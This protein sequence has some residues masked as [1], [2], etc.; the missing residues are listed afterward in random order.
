MHTVINKIYKHVLRRCVSYVRKSWQV[1][2]YVAAAIK[3]YR[4]TYLLLN[5]WY[6]NIMLNVWHC[7]IQFIEFNQFDRVMP[8]LEKDWDCSQ[9]NFD[10][11]QLVLVDLETY[12]ETS[13]LCTAKFFLLKS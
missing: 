10:A 8:A 2:Y 6:Y 1:F 5:F 7:T 13:L 9:L 11:I 12:L 3:L 4:L